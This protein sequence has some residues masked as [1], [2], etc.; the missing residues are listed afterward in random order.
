MFTDIDAFQTFYP[1]S[2]NP[3]GQCVN[4]FLICV[5][6]SERTEDERE[7][8][9]HAGSIGQR[10]DLV[11]YFC[12]LSRCYTAHNA[13]H[14]ATLISLPVGEVS[15]KMPA[16]SHSCSAKRPDKGSALND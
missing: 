15:I 9:Q 12:T 2:V 14:T 8:L 1:L 5:M 4:T 6:G 7:G 10:Q 3:K 11:H 16:L 13:P